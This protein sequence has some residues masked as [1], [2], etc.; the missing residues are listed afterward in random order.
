MWNPNDVPKPFET[1]K[2]CLN[3]YDKKRTIGRKDWLSVEFTQ[4]T[5]LNWEGINRIVITSKSI[6]V[7]NEIQKELNVL[8]SKLENE[9]AVSL[10]N[11]VD[12]V[13]K[14]KE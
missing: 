7:T 3:E 5:C 6:K 14:H 13:W 11:C 8:K 2:K 10:T 12:I 1:W 4:S 9:L